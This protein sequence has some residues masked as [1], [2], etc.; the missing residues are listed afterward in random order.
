VLTGLKLILRDVDFAAHLPEFLR[1]LPH[2]PSAVSSA[3]FPPFADAL[4][5]AGSLSVAA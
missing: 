4:A 2:A 5:P 1:H 3:P